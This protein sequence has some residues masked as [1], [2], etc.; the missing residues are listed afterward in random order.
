MAGG[1]GHLPLRGDP[2]FGRLTVDVVV[3]LA[4]VRMTAGDIASL[5]I[6]DIIPLAHAADYPVTLSVRGQPLASGDLMMNDEALAVR[7]SAVHSDEESAEDE[8]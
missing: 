3:E 2:L 1:N 7:L 6:H 5:T 4:R 8:E